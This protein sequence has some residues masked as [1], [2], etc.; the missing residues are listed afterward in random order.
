LEATKTNPAPLDAYESA[1]PDEPIFTL[2]G[3]DPLAAPLVRMWAY[4]ARVMAGLPGD[5]AM[6]DAPIYVAKMN[7]IAHDPAKCEELLT[8]ATQAEQVSWH[9]DGYRRGETSTAEMV[10]RMNDLDK[11]DVYDVRRRAVSTIS[12]FFSD[13]NDYR[14]QLLAHNFLTEETDNTMREAVATLRSVM[15]DIEIRRG[16]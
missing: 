7:S 16:N 10:A 11:L 12:A 2:Q 15:H 13:L 4:L 3:G 1:K 6:I 14:E 8:R 5:V 9:M